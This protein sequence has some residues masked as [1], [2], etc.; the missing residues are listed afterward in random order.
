MCI[1]YQLME[2]CCQSVQSGG[3]QRGR[4]PKPLKDSIVERILVFKR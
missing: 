3:T 2:N 1:V 4:S